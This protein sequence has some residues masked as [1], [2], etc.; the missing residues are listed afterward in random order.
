MTIGEKILKLRTKDGLSQGTLAEFL[1]VSRQSIS[2]WE[3]GQ[4]KPD[5]DK[6]VKLSEIFHVTVDYL[7]KDNDNLEDEQE[8]PAYEQ[9]IITN[10]VEKDRDKIPGYFL[11]AVGLLLVGISFIFTVYAALLGIIVLI[12]GIEWLVVKNNLSLV[13][14]WTIFLISV[15]IINPWTTSVGNT[16][17]LIQAIMVGKFTA[18]IVIGIIQRVYGIILLFVTIKRVINHIK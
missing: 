7:V 13:I 2:K 3:T 15:C 6:I 18:G 14:A 4:A 11:M 12:I 1:D 9:N 17:W 16:K 10:E 8:I 5:V